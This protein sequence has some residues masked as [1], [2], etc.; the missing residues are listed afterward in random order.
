MSQ[1]TLIVEHKTKKKKYGRQGKTPTCRNN[2][3]IKSSYRDRGES[4]N[5][6]VLT[7]R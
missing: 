1:L 7:Y 4:Q 5:Q 3:L 6:L 2:T